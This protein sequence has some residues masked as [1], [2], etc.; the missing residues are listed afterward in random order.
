[1]RRVS[2]WHKICGSSMVLPLCFFIL[3]VMIKKKDGQMVPN[4]TFRLITRRVNAKNMFTNLAL[5]QDVPEHY[6]RFAGSINPW[7]PNK[8]N[9][10]GRH[11]AAK[12]RSHSE[13][14]HKRDGRGWCDFGMISSPFCFWIVR[15]LETLNKFALAS[16]APDIV[17]NLYIITSF[18]KCNLLALHARFILAW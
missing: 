15:S 14:W 5:P 3:S 18:S 4:V 6:D 9:F 1:M 13:L 7:R 10:S 16:F 12:N 17:F 8:I 11:F 2:L